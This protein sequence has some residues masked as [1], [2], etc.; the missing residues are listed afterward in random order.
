MHV[1]TYE[2]EIHLSDYFRVVK[3][4]K[5][6]IAVFFVIVVAVTVVISFTTKP[7]YRATTTIFIDMESPNVLTATG[8]VELGGTNYYAYKEYFQSQKEIIK[9]RSVGRQAFQ[10]LGFDKDEEYSSEK[11]PLGAFLSTIKVEPVRDTRLLLLHVDNND[12]ELAAK[13]ANHLAET[14]VARNLA[15]ITNSEAMNLY[16]NELLKLQAKLSEY[17][18]VYKYKHPQ[19]IRLKQEIEQMVGRINKE[20]NGLAEYSE[21]MTS[22]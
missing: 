5:S 16:K 13:I 22:S 20:K 3:N 21:G 12:P 18:K 4:H 2:T 15:Y 10:E 19:M 17:S 1:Q 8:S 6:L 7:V 14:Y 11:D 9:S